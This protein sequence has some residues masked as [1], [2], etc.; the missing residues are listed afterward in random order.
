MKKILIFVILVFV[1]CLYG[2]SEPKYHEK[3][4]WDVNDEV[5]LSEYFTFYTTTITDLATSYDIDIEQEIEYIEDYGF[6]VSYETEDMEFFFNFINNSML[7]GV[8]WSQFVY[9][10][11]DI[12]DVFD[13]ELYRNYLN[14]IS[15]VNA[16]VSYDYQKIDDVYYEIYMDN[17]NGLGNTRI[18]YYDSIVGNIGYNIGW[19]DYYSS[20][21]PR[22][23]IQFDYNALLKVQD[24]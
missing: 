21:D 11:D 8:Y 7:D 20:S 22:A 6:C 15:D 12:E 1:S 17:L 18:F 4:G 16:I 24:F 23:Y 9:F 3:V 5:F 14:F 13:F 2:C 10:H 19:R